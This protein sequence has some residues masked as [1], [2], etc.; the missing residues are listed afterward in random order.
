M[1]MMASVALIA[2]A[3]ALLSPPTHA[4]VALAAH[5][6]VYDLTLLKSSGPKAPTQ[7]RGRIV[8]E[9]PQ[10]KISSRDFH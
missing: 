8:L 10:V 7:A 3:M 4:E 9:R 5:R 6:A 1:R 2:A